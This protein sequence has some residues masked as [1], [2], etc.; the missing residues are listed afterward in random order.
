MVQEPMNQSEADKQYFLAHGFSPSASGV[1]AIDF[2]GTL[3]PRVELFAYPQ[4]NSGAVAAIKRLKRAGFRIVIWTSRLSQDYTQRDLR[5][6][7]DQ[8][9]YVLTLLNR[10]GIPYD[11]VTGDKL[12]A[13]R[14]IDDRAI[15][16]DDNWQAIADFLVLTRATE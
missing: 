12:P 5:V 15:T 16:F 9:D 8:F 14:Y 13:E 1:L 11:D 4:P 7:S 10:D 2:D 3:Y 6:Y